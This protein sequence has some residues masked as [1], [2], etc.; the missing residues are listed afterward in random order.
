MTSTFFNRVWRDPVWSKVIAV[1]IIA[2][3]SFVYNLLASHFN[4]TNLRTEIIRFWTSR[5]YLWQAALL[6]LAA[7]STSWLGSYLARKKAYKYD[8]ETLEL[9]RGLFLKIRNEILPQD[10]I[11]AVKQSSFAENDFPAD[12]L[13]K[14]LNIIEEEKKSDFHFFHPALERMKEQL[15]LEV[16]EFGK[17]TGEYIFG[18]KG[19]K[20]LG[21]PREWVHD[22]PERFKEAVKKVYD[23]EIAMIQA[24]DQ[25]IRFGR[26]IL[27][28]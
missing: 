14:V 16:G 15:V 4:S 24:Y 7:L 1:G 12:L 21:I 25:F 17:V 27:K 26:L 11:F 2:V 28:V 18:A 22:Q 19:Q 13:F 5:I 10:L 20:M 9:D 6:I 3:I 23:Q 8:S